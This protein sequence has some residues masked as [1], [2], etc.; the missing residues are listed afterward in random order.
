MVP[1]A[2][3]VSNDGFQ[4]I[5]VFADKIADGLQGDLALVGE[6]LKV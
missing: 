2:V 4:C 1:L 3:D 6:G 5:I